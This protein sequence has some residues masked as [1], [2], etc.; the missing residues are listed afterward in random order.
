LNVLLESTPYFGDLLPFLSPFAESLRLNLE[1]LHVPAEGLH[2]A[3][4]EHSEARRPRWRSK[5][6][7]HDF[8]VLHLQIVNRER[9][10]PS[11]PPKER[12]MSEIVMMP[13]VY[14]VPGWTRSTSNRI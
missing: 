12:S 2:E 13:V 11:P 3:S 7:P 8:N 10:R 4:A 1:I 9:N 5:I 6:K 14:R